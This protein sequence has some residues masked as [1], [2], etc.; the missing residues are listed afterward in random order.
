MN[1]GSMT[2][3]ER[4]LTALAHRPPDRI[5][6]FDSFWPEFRDRCLQEL[7]LPQDVDLTEHFGI[8]IRIAIADE[9]P[10]PTRVAYLGDDGQTRTLRDGWGRVT[11]SVRGGFFSRELDVVVRQK[12]DLDRLVFDSPALEER[13]TGFLRNVAAWRDRYCVFCKTGGPY[14]R[15]SYLR[16]ETNFLTDIAADPGFARSLA[17]RVGEHIT[18]IGLESLRRGRLYDTGLWIYDDMGNNRQPMMSPASFERIFLPVYARMVRAFRQ[19]GAA[20]VVL[21]SDGNVAPLL[22]MLVDAGIDGF[23]PL[24]PRAGFHLPTVKQQYG[25]RLALIGGMCNSL[26]LPAGPLNRIR[27][28]TREIIQAG[29]DGGVVIGAHSIG[30]DIPVAH[31]Q[32]YRQVLVREGRYAAQQPRTPA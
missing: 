29:R 12:R 7:N 28:Q 24:E 23:N 31:Y 1:E 11:E 16:G 15:T 19:A 9:T 5:P 17:E 26:V 21:H 20:H 13:Y 30:P 14:L 3:K 4:V 32:A 25:K 18:R 10:F 6:T 27:A 2:S 8:D 22:D